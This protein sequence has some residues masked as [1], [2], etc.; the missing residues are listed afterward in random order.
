[1]ATATKTPA[2]FDHDATQL[3]VRHPLQILR[4]YIR[5]YVLLE[6]AALAIL[7]LAGWFWI[8]V[9]LDFGSFWSF[10]FDWVQSLRD[11]NPGTSSATL[12]RS[13]LLGAMLLALAALVFTKVALRWI[14]EFSDDSLALVLERRFPRELGDRLITAV[15]L[16]DPK[17]S[18][19]YG[20]SELLVEKT[21][22]DA[23]NTLE[24]L[25]VSEVFNWSRLRRMW[26]LVAAS[27]IGVYLLVGVAVCG[28][29][30]ATDKPVEP[31]E[32]LWKSADVGVIWG[33]RNLLL[34]NSY[35]PRRSHLEVVRFQGNRNNP[36]EM[37]VG[38]DE[39]RPDVQVRA[40]QWVV[41]DSAAPEGWRALRW[42]DLPQYLDPVEVDAVTQA[43]P[44]D[45]GYWT[46]D[47]DDLDV[48]VPAGVLP[49]NLQG[50]TAGQV[51]E[52]ILDPTIQGN[53]AVQGAEKAVADLLD[54]KQWTVD[55]LQL[56]LENREVRH[57]LPEYPKMET[58]FKQLGEL[59]R[60]PSMSRRL[61]KLTLP[62]QVEV[63]YRGETTKSSAPGGRPVDN[64]FSIGLNDLKESVRFRV[65]GEDY[66]TPT[67]QITLVPPPAITTLTADKREPA[68]LY[69]RL[70]G[71]DQGALK[72][73][74]QVLRDYKL[75]ISGDTTTIDVPVGADL[76][77]VARPDVKLQK[78]IRIRPP[79]TPDLGSTV[80]PGP[81]VV[82]D[83]GMSFSTELK[84]VTKPFDFILE[85]N[86]ED[87]VSGRRRF[88]VRPVEDAPP[89][90]INLDLLVSLR[91]PKY[92][93]DPGK[94]VQAAPVDG[95]LITPDALVPFNG[96][97]RDDHGLVRA[98]WR[99]DV[100][101]IDFELLG[102]GIDRKGGTF[103]LQGNAALRRAGLI[104]SAFQYLPHSPN[105]GA[106]GSAYIAWASSFLA[107]DLALSANMALGDGFKEME[108]FDALLQRKSVGEVAVAALPD[109]LVSAKAP[110][111]QGRWEHP[112]KDEPGFDLR[113]HLPKLKSLDPEKV[114]QL[115]YMV[116]VNVALTDNNVEAGKPF[117][118][119]RG[120]SYL[121]VT[122]RGKTAYNF[123]VVSERELLAQIALEEQKL[124]EDLEK[125]LDRVSYGVTLTDD[126]IRKFSSGGASDLSL[127]VLRVDE[128]RKAIL[129]SATTTRS[130][131][132]DYNR[133]LREMEVNRVNSKT[134]TTVRDKICI[135]LGN[136]VQAEQGSFARC[137]EAVQL[138]HGGIDE[139][140]SKNL[141]GR[142][143]LHARNLRE[144]RGQL[145]TLKNDINS[146]LITMGL[147]IEIG[148][149]R[150]ILVES[151][152]E[153]RRQSEVLRI[154]FDDRM[155]ELG[156][157]LEGLG[158]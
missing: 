61:R 90:V 144:L 80:A 37:R 113:K 157:I 10:A 36:A 25:P 124:F 67:K 139:D 77:L 114:G 76:K 13:F 71:T 9:L 153:Q 93:A 48:S 120:R 146:I 135:P 122:A 141:P 39:S 70:Q 34:M 4:K 151:E 104:A 51:R 11:L 26:L 69:H 14:K 15:E 116:R 94:A 92:K 82:A 97:L 91:K 133:I 126:Q 49:A 32:Y 74:T 78:S 145:E 99:Y 123:I 30:L 35:W 18:K 142:G 40:V 23:A 65:R 110:R 95:F 57:A 118:D 115:H 42:N 88:K 68:Y 59:A 128:I 119:D 6:G 112:L 89:E 152:R 46:I 56:Q 64:K 21:I 3:R 79:V 149:L 84:K 138:A 105:S 1:M 5:S 33:E 28:I 19:K 150:E 60:S 43:V 63:Y 98:A 134:L 47:L 132:T 101:Q 16:A 158:K 45:W 44:A 147:G 58:I 41:A 130:V 22:Q 107:T 85:Y 38:R 108:E 50:K 103:V 121:G 148:K 31:E 52:A 7:F 143:D 100:E 83:D 136:L 2:P 137:E 81:V 155:R 12:V 131:H 66:Y 62:D 96:V 127:V 72:G 129:D 156:K 27:T 20:F 75:P 53:I 102:Q 125:V 106:L 117:K 154:I 17:V 55:K 29:S 87:G 8:G 111:M 140:A 54:W 86:D 109:L 73:K 24:K